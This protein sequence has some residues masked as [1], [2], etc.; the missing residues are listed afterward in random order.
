MENTTILYVND[1]VAGSG[2]AMRATLS[3]LGRYP[4]LEANSTDEALSLLQ[5]KPPALVILDLRERRAAV[6]ACVEIRQRAGF[7]LPLIVLSDGNGEQDRISA[8]DAGA[9][10]YL[11]RPCGIPELLA[12][13]RA[14]VRRARVPEA[15][16]E[17][18]VSGDLKIDLERRCAIRAGKRMHL[19]PKEHDVLQVL[20]RHHDKP[21]T[22][23][24]LLQTVWGPEYGDESEY[25][26]TI[27]RQLRKKIEPEP[28]KPRHLLTERS[29]G[30]LFTTQC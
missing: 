11:R 24:K 25:L 4:V 1:D 3:I 2:R 10:D 18:V 30:Y 9:D 15:E 5:P 8:L 12:R 27:M 17:V 28:S 26:R 6:A 7:T 22:H 23:R 29:L 19:T 13:I 20:V 14:H 16:E 21:V